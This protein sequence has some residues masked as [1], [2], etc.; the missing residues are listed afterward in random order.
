MSILDELREFF[1]HEIVIERWVQDDEHGTP[2]FDE[3]HP[4][5]VNARIVGRTKLVSAE[6]GREH[7]SSVQ[8][9]LAG[10]YQI[11]AKDRFTLPPEF[12]SNPRDP[13]DLTARRPQALAVDRSS[14]ENGAH[15][16][17]VQ[18]SNAR[19]RSF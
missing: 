14:D 2:Q 19:I 17:T 3:E 12:S 8:A 13:N 16:E 18:F 6:D 9:T 15:H 1:P 4:L 10:Y 7:V 11:S 5:T